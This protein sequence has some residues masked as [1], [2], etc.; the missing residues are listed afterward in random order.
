MTRKT[1]SRIAGFTFLFYIAVAF[2]ATILLERA[3]GGAGIAA[4]LANVARHAAD[5]RLSVVLSLLGCF[6][7]LVLA[8]TLYG[9]TRD[10]DRDLARLAF[11]CRVAEGVVGGTSLWRPLGLLWLATAGGA[12]AP[13]PA[14]AH[15]LGAFLL[16]GQ[17]AINGAGFFAL[18][19]T[20][21][22]CLLLRGRV[23]P[24]PLAWLGVVSSALLAVVLPLRLAGFIPHLGWLF[25]MPALVFEVALALWLLVKGAAA[26]EKAMD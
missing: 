5:V 14:A 23:V 4:K 3:A 25:W 22:S 2:P 18:G 6:S 24:V 1:N 17:G 7:A 11:A 10:V 26:P 15:A 12:N 21:F 9:I 19:S 20:L 16:M 13:D 8:V